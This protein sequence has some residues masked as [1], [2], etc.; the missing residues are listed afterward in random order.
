MPT[1]RHFI[2]WDRP[3]T[4][5]VRD[6][7]I[8]GAITQSIDL[9]ETLV[10]VPTRQASRRLREALAAHCAAAD[11]AMLSA[12]M[13]VPAA[14]FRPEKQADYRETS[15]IMTQAIWGDVLLSES[16]GALTA[17]FPSPLANRD[18]AWAERTGQSIQN[19]R[20]TLADGGYTIGDVLT[21]YA[22]E[23]EEP[24]RWQELAEVEQ[25]YL[26]HVAGL[27]Y[28]DATIRKIE[29]ASNPIIPEGIT[30]VVVAA[31]PDPSL[32][33]LR[34]LTAIQKAL[35]VEILVAAP[36]SLSDLFD[37]WG[38]PIPDAWRTRD[39]DIPDA[40]KTVIL[41]G[42]PK[43]QADHTLQALAR[44]VNRF[45]PG[46]IAIGVPDR[47]VIPFIETS[48]SEIGL[49]VFDP[50]DKFLRDHP[51]F[52]LLDA[53]ASLHATRGYT[54]LRDFIRH[55]DIL[56]WLEAK[57]IA[58]DQV[59]MDL[60]ALQNEHI[61]LRLDDITVHLPPEGELTTAINMI[62]DLL[63]LFDDTPAPTA[64]RELFRHVYAKRMISNKNADDQAFAAA[65][66]QL[67][68]ILKEFADC[69]P[70]AISA[71]TATAL[72]LLVQRISDQTYHA[73]REDSQID[74][75]G[76][77]ELPW[78]DAP[79]LIATGLN[80]GRVPDGRLSDIF[81]PDTMRQHLELRSDAGRLARD[82]Y[83]MTMLIE[84]RRASGKTMFIVGKTSAAGDPL[85][86]SRLLFRCPQQELAGRAKM[87]FDDI[88]EREPHHA[89]TVS[90]TLDPMAPLGDTAPTEC[91]R[92]LSATSFRSYL[93]CPFRFYLG[94]VLHMGP[95][96]DSKREL[97][98]L[99]FG[100][101]IHTALQRMG[102]SDMWQC[103]DPEALAGFLM[104]QIEDSVARQFSHPAP[105]PVQVSLDAARQR[106]RQA[107]H[108]QVALVR[109]GWRIERTEARY[110]MMLDGMPVSGIIDRVDR[111]GESGAI[112]IIDYKTSDSAATPLAAHI[113]TCRAE[114][115]DFAQVTV[116]GKAKRWIDLQLPLYHLLLKANGLIDGDSALAYFNLPKA[117][118]QTGIDTWE[119]W[120]PGLLD[121]ASDCA[122]AIIERIGN[123][124]FWPPASRVSYDDYE[125]LFPADPED[126]FT[127]VTSGG[128]TP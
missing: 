74:L 125:L 102:E 60:D 108:A 42:T 17:L 23:L 122:K 103:D 26:S 5:T 128:Q 56:A 51:L 30:R 73:E 44:E 19:L 109:E 58:A 48:L 38:R 62:C 91:V 82:A 65:A 114:T 120:T 81:L 2:G 93:A 97:D 20:E 110:E 80:E 54:A 115:P 83:L 47:T 113:A 53:F 78:N 98:A 24:E 61:P 92:K 37:A 49:S 43:S 4:Q 94:N 68:E 16:T 52:G 1:Q 41:A 118:M 90:F 87:L 35:P 57:S 88:D 70:A 123:G 55:P 28:K 107:A 116:E 84:T 18:A 9:G 59:L 64:T 75:E 101:M 111:H 10:I 7:L 71:D 13:A 117:V 104:S 14:L 106:L 86:P 112:R 105:L 99:D 32:L 69:P 22:D 25:S 63:K 89:S 46:D 39:I 76:W 21:Q 6:F 124:V 33:M 95:V 126:C 100:S 40:D 66:E 72:R 11:A 31:V 3:V 79:F 12:N 27:G 85:K 36:D 127:P 15:G 45:G 50:S 67:S 119:D 8:P 96:D 34:A 121:S 29:Q 77:L